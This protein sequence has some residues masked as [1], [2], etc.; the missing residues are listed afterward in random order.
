[1]SKLSMAASNKQGIPA[2]RRKN[3]QI[4]GLCQYRYFGP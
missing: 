1:M 4:N 3:G 2:K